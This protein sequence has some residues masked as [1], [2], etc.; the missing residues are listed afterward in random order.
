[1]SATKAISMKNLLN[2]TKVFSAS[3]VLAMAFAGSA[4]AL[5][6]SF[7]NAS[8]LNGVAQIAAD[9]SGL[10]SVNVPASNLTN[11]SNGY[12]VETFDKATQTLQPDFIPDGLGGFIPNP[13]A[14]QPFPAGTMAYNDAGFA[15]CAV[16][17]V[18]SGI[19]I[20]T[21]AAGAF[22]VRQGSVPNKAAA[23]ANDETC[24]G[25]TPQDRAVLPSWVEVDYSAFLANAGDVG[26]TFLGFYWGSIDSYND[27]TFYAGTREIQTITGSQLLSQSGGTSG[28]QQGPGSNVYV[29]ID[30]TLANAFDKVRITSRRV[31]GE[32]DNIVIGLQNRPDRPVPA[33]AGLA[34][35]ALGLLGLGLKKRFSK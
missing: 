21:S 22:G 14:G 6:I 29:A 4:S 33:P 18:G 32:F 11:G 12:F 7:G 20:A 9:G 3:L 35:L 25:Y 10:T 23:P 24:F 5:T 8:N 30:F 34:F 15:D 16:N 27:F 31:A 1:M 19:T 17:G 13:T 28:D 26:I 2:K